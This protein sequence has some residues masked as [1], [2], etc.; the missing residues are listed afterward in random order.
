VERGTFVILK[1]ALGLHYSDYIEL[2]S[3]RTLLPSAILFILGTVYLFIIG[4]FK[5]G[6]QG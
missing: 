1:A 6:V 5:G 2:L 3:K 4:G